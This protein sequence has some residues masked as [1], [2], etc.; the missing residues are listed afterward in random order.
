MNENQIH[1]I[2][3]M[4][5]KVWKRAKVERFEEIRKKLKF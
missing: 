4:W 2:P 3:I 1:L 5:I